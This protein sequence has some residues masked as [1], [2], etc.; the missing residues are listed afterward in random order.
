MGPLNMYVFFDLTTGY[1]EGGL[2]KTLSLDFSLPE[3]QLNSY[4]CD[5]RFY[6][7]RAIRSF[8]IVDLIRY[9]WMCKFDKEALLICF[10]IEMK[11]DG[12]LVN[13]FGQSYLGCISRKIRKKDLRLLVDSYQQLTQINDSKKI[14]SMPLNV[15]QEKLRQTPFSNEEV[16]YLIKLYEENYRQVSEVVD[17]KA[18]RLIS[19]LQSLPS[20]VRRDF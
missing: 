11:T 7:R 20:I 1:D 17:Q 3:N 9:Y 19:Q 8:S 5:N 12:Y 14:F 4:F 18:S 15:V 10:P 2:L 13:K 6:A 16:Q